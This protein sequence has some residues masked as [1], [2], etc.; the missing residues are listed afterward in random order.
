MVRQRLCGGNDGALKR[1]KARSFQRAPDAKGDQRVAQ[2]RAGFPYRGGYHCH[3]GYVVA[4]I[5]RKPLDPG[6]PDLCF[7][8]VKGRRLI[9][10]QYL[11]PGLQLG[12]RVIA[13]SGDTAARC[14]DQCRKA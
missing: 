4:L 7:P 13:K 1:R 8:L 6:L 2:L 10:A 11:E 12:F 9:P 14:A 5:H 3:A